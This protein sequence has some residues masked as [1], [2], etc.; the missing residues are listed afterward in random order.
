MLYG[1][2]YSQN[3]PDAV[4]F[5]TEEM[6]QGAE[7]SH[8]GAIPFFCAAMTGEVNRLGV[9]IDVHGSLTYSRDGEGNYPAAST[10]KVWFW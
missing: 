8:R 5:V 9:V 7:L 2:E 4:A 6:I 3:L 1:V 10:E